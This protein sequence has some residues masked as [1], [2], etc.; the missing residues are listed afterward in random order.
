MDAVQLL[1]E[2][3]PDGVR[4]IDTITLRHYYLDENL[5]KVNKYAKGVMELCQEEK[6]TVGH[7]QKN[8][9]TTVPILRKLVR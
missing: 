2:Y 6:Q 5:E 1:L 7:C 8:A 4:P 9:S 3:G